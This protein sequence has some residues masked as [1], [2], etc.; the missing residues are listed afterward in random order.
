MIGN[1]YNN[2]WPWWSQASSNGVV[3]PVFTH[4]TDQDSPATI[5]YSI[6][7]SKFTR[8][9]NNYHTASVKVTGFKQYYLNG[10]AQDTD[11]VNNIE[12]GI[13]NVKFTAAL[14]SYPFIANVKTTFPVNSVLCGSKAIPFTRNKD[15]ATFTVNSNGTYLVN[16]LKP[17]VSAFSASPLNGKAPLTVKFTDKSTNNPTSWYWDFGDNSTSTVQNPVHTYAKAGE[18]T[19][20]LTVKNSV[21]TNSVSKKSYIIVK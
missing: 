1:I 11:S 12:S 18:F 20:K 19:I 4:R 21:G 5:K 7:Y 15:G 9:V 6:D 3:Y 10:I 2:T 8:W 16:A 13:S 17:P 14:N